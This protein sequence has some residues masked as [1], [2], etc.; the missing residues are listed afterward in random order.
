[1]RAGIIDR[2]RDVAINFAGLERA[3]VGTELAFLLAVWLLV[4]YG[5]DTESAVAAVIETLTTA[6][7]LD[8]LD[9]ARIDSGRTP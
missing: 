6:Q 8:R 4:A 7:N 5:N 2:I 3:V 9:H 1:M